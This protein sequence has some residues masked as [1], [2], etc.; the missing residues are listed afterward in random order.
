MSVVAARYVVR[1]EHTLAYCLR[2]HG[3]KVRDERTWG[4]NPLGHHTTSSVVP[5]MSEAATTQSIAK[6]TMEKY[7]WTTTVYDSIDWEAIKQGRKG[8]SKRDN[9]RIT[10]LMFDWVNTGNQKAKMHQE[11]CCP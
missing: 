7:K 11:N 10:K 4:I 5:Y 6:Y 2:F 8:Y 3:H 1:K 9:I